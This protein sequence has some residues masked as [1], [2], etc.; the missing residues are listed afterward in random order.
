VEKGGGL[1]M[2][3]RGRVMGRG[4]GVG[5]GWEKGEGYGWR[6]EGRVMGGKRYGDEKEEGYGWEK[7]DG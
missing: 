5:Y 7:G 1:R 4:N 3:K 2:G 6:K